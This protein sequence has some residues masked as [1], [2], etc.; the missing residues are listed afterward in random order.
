MCIRRRLNKNGSQVFEDFSR[1]PAAASRTC[2]EAGGDPKEAPARK[3]RHPGSWRTLSCSGWGEP[4]H[5]VGL[6]AGAGPR[7][8]IKFDEIGCISVKGCNSL[9]C[10]FGDELPVPGDMIVPFLFTYSS[11]Y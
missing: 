6:P 2:S 10:A 11:E 7:S 3:L 4:R 8:E 1:I 5:I 9:E